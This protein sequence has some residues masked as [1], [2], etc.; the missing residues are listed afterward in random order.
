MPRRPSTIVSGQAGAAAAVVLSAA[1]IWLAMAPRPLLAADDNPARSRDVSIRLGARQTITAIHW[2]PPQAPLAADSPLADTPHPRPR[3]AGFSPLVAVA[4]SDAAPNDIEFVH[5][6]EPTYTGQTLNP[7]VF[8]RFVVGYLDSGSEV[9]LAAGSAA[10]RLGLSGSVLTE[11]TTELTG[12][13]GSE[14]AYITN[15]IAFFA[16]GFSNITAPDTLNFSALK[17]HSNVSALAAPPIDCGFGEV[18]NAIVGMPF[19]AFYTTAILVESPQVVTVS[20]RTYTSPEVQILDILDPSPAL[21]HDFTREIGLL[22]QSALAPWAITANYYPDPLDIDGPPFIPTT[23]SPFPNSIPAGG[24]FYMDILVLEGT[25]SPTNPARTMH[26]LVDTGAQSSVITRA[27]ASR[28]SLPF[29]PDFAIDVCGIGGVTPNIPAYFVDYVR[30]DAL[31]GAL[32]FSQA[33]FVMLDS[34]TGP[35]GVTI[36]GILGMN[37]FWNRNVLFAPDPPTPLISQG[38]LYVSDPI[39]FAYGDFDLSLK[40]A[41][42]DFELFDFCFAGPGAALPP[43][44]FHT[45]GDDDGDLDLRDAAAFQRCFSG[46]AQAD[47]SCGP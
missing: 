20:G 10:D 32:E 5:Q 21:E 12:I 40:V 1:A 33:P 6:L 41:S 36:D 15:P 11:N 14:L 16:A 24:A 27:M 38:F 19:L 31:G 39:P 35:G 4:T 46:T 34:L 2:Q 22:F 47:S 26:V 3:L 29:T 17:G 7:F 23:L 25:V 28:L 43:D 18:V 30:I 37:F 44:C 13:S 9:D 42:D 45:D 8:P